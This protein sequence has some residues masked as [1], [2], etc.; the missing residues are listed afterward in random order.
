MGV[1]DCQGHTIDQLH[2]VSQNSLVGLFDSIDGSYPPG[3]VKNLGLT[4]VN[5]VGTATSSDGAYP[6]SVGGF[7]GRLGGILIQTY[8]TGSVTATGSGSAIS[9]GGLV[10]TVEGKLALIRD[11]YSMASVSGGYDA[12]GLAGNT[13]NSISG[14]IQTS[15]ATGRVMGGTNSGG[16]LMPNVGPIS[17]FVT[18][19]YWDTESSG[20]MTSGGGGVGLTTA[21]FKSGSH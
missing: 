14:Q 3:Y 16:L 9:V 19:S 12:A 5:I 11:S 15:Y 13:W 21:Q 7:A 1:L 8:V 17:A 2:I 6:V 4:N 10:G 20:Q 18:S